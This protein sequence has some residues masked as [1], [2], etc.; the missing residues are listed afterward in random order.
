[1]W[2]MPPPRS[3]TSCGQASDP[4]HVGLE[5]GGNGLYRAGGVTPRMW[6]EWLVIR[7]LKCTRLE[8]MEVV[9]SGPVAGVVTAR[10]VV[11]HVE[12]HA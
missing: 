6:G 2:D 5:G 11:S 8:A 4:A 10:P 3:S 1:M 12:A 7:A 9:V